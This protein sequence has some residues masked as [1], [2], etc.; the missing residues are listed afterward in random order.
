MARR[1]RSSDKGLEG[2]LFILLVGYTA[3]AKFWES[4]TAEEKRIFGVLGILALIAA[5]A[6]IAVLIEYRKRK[7][8]EAWRKALSAFN[9]SIR[10]GREP[11][12]T[13]QGLS[14]LDLEKLAARVYRQMGYKAYLTDP[15]GDH[16][17]DVRLIAPNGEVEVVQCKQW[18]E[19]V[20]EAVVRD[21]VGAMVHEKAVKGYIWAPGG[22]SQPAKQWAKGKPVKLMDNDAIGRLVESAYSD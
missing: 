9:Q 22:F 8:R 20:G 19:P 14:P 5:V 13:A 11:V 16:G 17:V 18:N 1:R 6:F 4:L 3:L 7:R 15:S 2:L 12:F 21:L 10:D